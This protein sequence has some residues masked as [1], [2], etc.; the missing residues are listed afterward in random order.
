MET[1]FIFKL[2]SKYDT[3]QRS[4]FLLIVPVVIWCRFLWGGRGLAEPLEGISP[5]ATR[6][7]IKIYS[8]WEENE[9]LYLKNMMTCSSIMLH[10][11]QTDH[12]TKHEQQNPTLFQFIYRSASHHFSGVPSYSNHI[13]STSSA[14]IT[15]RKC[16]F[17]LS[18]TR[19]R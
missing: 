9:I 19:V 16:F 4:S 17:T 11:W 18:V 13:S 2:T 12:K 10:I 8:W 1:L 15:L 14:F 3:Q 7:N 6:R 5:R